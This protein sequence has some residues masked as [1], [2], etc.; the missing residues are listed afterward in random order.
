M[1]WHW[2]YF[3]FAIA[4]LAHPVGAAEAGAGTRWEA[5]D[6]SDYAV[7]LET[8]VDE[9]GMVDYRGLKAK[10]GPLLSY[11]S[12]I[13]N[14]SPDEYRAWDDPAKIAFWINAY[15]GLTLKA[16]I[17]HY[18]IKASFL[19]SLV[20]PSNSIRQIDGV[21]DEIEFKVL[22]QALTLEQ[23]EHEIL[24]KKFNE[25]RIHMALVCAAMGCP[26]LR[27]EPYVGG[28]LDEQLADQTRRFLGDPEKF[29]IDRRRKRV[30]LSSIFKWFAEDFVET[31]APAE[32][33][34]R[35]DRETSAVLN[36]VAS[37]LSEA[38]RTYILSGNYRIKYF[39]YDWSLN[40]QRTEQS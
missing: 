15:N 32:E 29:R 25:P 35:F 19:K 23:I 24:R 28:R 40:E 6:Y 14:L 21:W 3:G 30:Y 8:Y 12:A 26:P 4:L 18:P 7:L 16:I 27:R 31:Y 34:G 10:P 11:A 1:R 36:F 38:D 9:R 13:A 22:R 2:S 17:D 5:F 39:D 20:Y 37:Y 33:I